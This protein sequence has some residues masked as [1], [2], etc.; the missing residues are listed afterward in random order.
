MYDPNPILLLLSETLDNSMTSME[1]HHFHTQVFEVARPL[2][3][4]YDGIPLPSSGP[5]TSQCVWPLL[6]LPSLCLCATQKIY[7]ALSVCCGL[8]NLHVIREATPKGSSN[9]KLNVFDKCIF[10]ASNVNRRCFLLLKENDKERLSDPMTQAYGTS[11][12][13]ISTIDE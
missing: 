3:A 11:P 7:S 12:L 6:L 5:S 8:K 10:F 9:S 4:M 1:V 13:Y 2:L